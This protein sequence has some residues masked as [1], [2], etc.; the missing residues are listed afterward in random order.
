MV[1]SRFESQLVIHQTDQ[2]SVSDP[3]LNGEVA[4]DAHSK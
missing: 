1:L 2:D 4:A 3:A